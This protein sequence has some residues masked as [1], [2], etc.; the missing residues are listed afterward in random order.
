M[1]R[2]RLID[3]RLSRLL[4]QLRARSIARD[5]YQA[6]KEPARV[7]LHELEAIEAA[8]GI[9]LPDPVIA[10][11]AAGVSVWGDGPLRLAKVAEQTAH[12]RELAVEMFQSMTEAAAKR[13][14]IIDDDSNGNYIAVKKRTPKDSD[15]VYFLDHEGGYELPA[16]SLSLM[17]AITDRL[18]DAPPDAPPLAI[19][20]IDEPAPAPRARRVQHPKF[21]AGTVHADDGEYVSV[22]F[23][24]GRK[25]MKREFLTFE[26]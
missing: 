10:Y 20:W 9:E 2:A 7:R 25:R 23:E 4:G 18:G 24:A 26:D 13:F 16:A 21:G 11:L 17:E 8:T 5:Q 15:A 1:A 19:E 3:P 22:D 6:P 14:A 12:V